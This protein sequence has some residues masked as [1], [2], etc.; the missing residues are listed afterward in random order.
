[1]E[2][3]RPTVKLIGEDSNAHYIMGKVCKAL[4]RNGYSDEELKK[5]LEEAK[6]GDY[7]NLLQVTDEWVDIE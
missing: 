1:M 6:S 4:R 5:Y 7:D 3:E 2:K